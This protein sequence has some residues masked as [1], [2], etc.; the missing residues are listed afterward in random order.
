[1]G[2]S[3]SLTFTTIQSSAVTTVTLVGVRPSRRCSKKPVAWATCRAT[4]GSKPRAGDLRG[5]CEEVVHAGNVAG[6]F[7]NGSG[8]P[9]VSKRKKPAGETSQRTSLSPAYAATDHPDFRTAPRL[10]FRQ[11][12]VF[13]PTCKRFFGAAQPIGAA[14]YKWQSGQ[15]KQNFMPQRRRLNRGRHSF[16]NPSWKIP[17]LRGGSLWRRS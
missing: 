15:G 3:V 4:R 10:V 11:F 13:L 14:K 2:E 8:G 16:R 6:M 12:F 17:R 5:A 1:M 7:M 9:V